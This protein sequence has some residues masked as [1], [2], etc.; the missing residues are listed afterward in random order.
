MY[1]AMT[2]GSIWHNRLIWK[3]KL[4]LKIKTF[5]WYLNKGVILIKDNLVRRNWTGSTSC[6]FCNS[7][8]TIQH[9]FLNAIMLNYYGEHCISPLVYKV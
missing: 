8:E 5:L 7:E 2:I 4:P 1:N 3:L 6:A 9:L